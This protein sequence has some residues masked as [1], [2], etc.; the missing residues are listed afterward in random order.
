M[1]SDG[2]NMKRSEA[3]VEESCSAGLH[4]DCLC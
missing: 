3:A 4:Q 1:Y 2:E